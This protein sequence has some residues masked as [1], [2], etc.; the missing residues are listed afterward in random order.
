MANR[1]YLYSTDKPPFGDGKVSVRGLSEWNSEVPLVYK[2]LLGENPQIATSAIWPEQDGIAL[3]SD[4]AGGVRRLKEFLENIRYQPLL[5]LGFDALEFLTLPENRRSYFLLEAGEIFDLDETQELTAQCASLREEILTID[6]FTREWTEIFNQS[7]DSEQRSSLQDLGLGEW[8][9][10]LYFDPN[11]KKDLRD[12]PGVKF[13]TITPHVIIEEVSAKLDTVIREVCAGDELL[14]TE[15]PTLSISFSEQQTAHSEETGD[16]RF[17]WNALASF[18]EGEEEPFTIELLIE[19]C[20]AEQ[21]L[22]NMSWILFP[23]D[24][25]CD[26]TPEKYFE[27]LKYLNT[28]NTEFAV[29]FRFNDQP[30]EKYI[31]CEVCVPAYAAD[32]DLVS[33][34]LSESL[35]L[36]MEHFE[37]MEEIVRDEESA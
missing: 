28:V 1:A 6:E 10:T 4:Y 32:S 31:S 11:A 22:L 34:A 17:I 37:A 8:S 15:W 19:L 16:P 29:K 3:V 36:S 12:T 26:L 5:A 14:F 23:H 18:D 2:I 7:T 13:V 21:P 20:N 35:T 30:D 9:N 27:L 25:V 33:W 24:E